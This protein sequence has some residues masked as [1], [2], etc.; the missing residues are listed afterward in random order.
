MGACLPQLP[1]YRLQPTHNR[2]KCFVTK[3]K[4]AEQRPLPEDGRGL[5][6]TSGNRL[7]SRDC[8]P[9]PATENAI[10]LCCSCPLNERLQLG[11]NQSHSVLQQSVLRLFLSRVTFPAEVFAIL[12]RNLSEFPSKAYDPAFDVRVIHR[13]FAIAVSDAPAARCS[14]LSISHAAKQKHQGGQAVA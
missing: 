14:P 6:F 1:S 4:C 12:L 5:G 11:T 2:S 7:R 13:R 3:W 10:S 8:L 9:C